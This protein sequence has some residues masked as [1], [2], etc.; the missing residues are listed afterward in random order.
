VGR[1][2]FKPLRR[3]RGAGKR[4]RLTLRL[5]PAVRAAIAAKSKPRA[6]LTLVVKDAGGARST[7]HV[8]I[9]L[10]R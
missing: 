4:V 5:T 1:A 7:T 6:R 2:K 8:T 10:K 3:K 9:K